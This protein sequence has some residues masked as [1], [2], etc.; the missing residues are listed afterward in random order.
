M[1]Q[2]ELEMSQVA[3]SILTCYTLD[4]WKMSQVTVSRLT[5]YRLNRK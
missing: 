2:A 4:E 5:F 3:V 1:L